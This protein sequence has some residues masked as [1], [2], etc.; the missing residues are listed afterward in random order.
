MLL[1]GILT[2]QIISNGEPVVMEKLIAYMESLKQKIV[3]AN[4]ELCQ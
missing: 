2:E 3:K 4:E 1:A